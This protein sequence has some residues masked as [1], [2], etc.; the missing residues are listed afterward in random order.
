LRAYPGYYL[1]ATDKISTEQLK[2]GLFRDAA[3]TANTIT[4]PELQNIM[5][6]IVR[7][8]YV[9]R[10]KTL[11]TGKPQETIELLWKLGLD[12]R[13][14]PVQSQWNSSVTLLWTRCQDT[15]AKEWQ[16]LI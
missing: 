7:A 9:V 1:P 16:S 11:A 5:L 14:Q 13:Q 4:A 10:V 12:L 8:D 2:R 15:F 3:A 6:E